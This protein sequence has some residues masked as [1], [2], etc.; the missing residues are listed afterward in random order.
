MAELSTEAKIVVA[1]LWKHTPTL[2]L[3]FHR[4]WIITEKA[5]KG[6]DELVS[7][8]LLTVSDLDGFEGGLTWAPTEEMKSA[9][10]VDLVFLG[11]F[12][13]DLVD[14]NRTAT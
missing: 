3:A 12:G 11:E 14:E 6:L 4:P 13:F 10:K 7:E 2:E 5:R 8:K 9:P 1:A